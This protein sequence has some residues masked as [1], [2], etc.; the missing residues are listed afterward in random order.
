MKEFWVG[1]IRL[2]GFLAFLLA[3][4]LEHAA[5]RKAGSWFRVRFMFIILSFLG[6][7]TQ[8][9]MCKTEIPAGSLRL[10]IDRSRA[11]EPSYGVKGV[12]HREFLHNGSPVPY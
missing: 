1:S 3:L 5:R 10:S 4:S 2:E 7:F 9:L 11:Q 6:S 12:R 8:S